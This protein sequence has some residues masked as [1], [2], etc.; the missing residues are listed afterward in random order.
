M[1]RPGETLTVAP[2]PGGTHLFDA[3]SGVRL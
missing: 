3:G 2:D 1:L